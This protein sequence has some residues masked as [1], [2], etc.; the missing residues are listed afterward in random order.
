[1]AVNFPHFWF[2]VISFCVVE[3]IRRARLFR[4]QVHFLIIATTQK[5]IILNRKCAKVTATFVLVDF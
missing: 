5:E 4:K 1:M 3:T 2:S